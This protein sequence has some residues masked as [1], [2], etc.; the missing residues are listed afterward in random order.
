[1]TEQ[2]HFHF[3]SKMKNL[4]AMDVL[5]RRMIKFQ[6]TL[7]LRQQ[8]FFWTYL[9]ELAAF[10]SKTLRLILES[11]HHDLQ[12]SLTHTLLLSKDGVL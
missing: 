12:V 3:M 1:M 7:F 6:S 5:K 4:M 2:L 11:V 10:S 8:S 9:H